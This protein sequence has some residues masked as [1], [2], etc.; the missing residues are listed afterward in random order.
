M[1]C[2]IEKD[3]TA[4]SHERLKAL[5]SSIS[6][7]LEEDSSSAAADSPDFVIK[8]VTSVEGDVSVNQRKGRVKQLFDLVIAF[9]FSCPKSNLSGTGHIYEFTADFADIS[10]LNIRFSPRL[11]NAAVEKKFLT[12]LKDVLSGFKEDLF[13]VH[14]KPLLVNLPEAQQEKEKAD[15]STELKNIN[16]ASPASAP[17]PATFIQK[18]SS[19]VTST[20]VSTEMVTIE[21]EVEFPCPPEQ[22]F[23]MLT[24]SSR[25]CGWSRSPPKSLPQIILPQAPFSLFDGN[26]SGKFLSFSSPSSIEMEWKLKTWS[27]P[28]HVSIKIAPSEDKGP[29]HS[30]LNIVQKGV[31]AASAEGTKSN[32]HNYYWNPIKRAFGIMI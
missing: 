13:Q 14:G 18:P 21:D 9:D 15:I 2:R 23:L 12:I 24:D 29:M 31:P 19:A 32:W 16:L 11:N 1:W 7:A 10:D 25:I 22:L 3:C 20:P 8:A 27:A 30:V 6:F 4:W 17:A 5:F 28:S 26:I